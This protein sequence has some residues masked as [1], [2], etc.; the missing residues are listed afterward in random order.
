MKTALQ[1]AN[2]TYAHWGDELAT[3]KAKVSGLTS[4]ASDVALKAAKADVTALESAAAA[5][6][7]TYNEKKALA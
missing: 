2:D 5:K 3:E 6:L 7:V 4:A 1:N